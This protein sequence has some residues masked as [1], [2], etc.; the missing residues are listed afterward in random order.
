ML[1][2]DLETYIEVNKR[3][4]EVNIKVKENQD[5]IIAL[6]SACKVVVER[7]ATEQEK[8]T[9]ALTDISNAIFKL[10]VVYVAGLLAIVAQIIEIFMK[11]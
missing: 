9:K 6:L 2:K 1:D 5:A 4:T 10:E 11:K 3:T 7:L 8:Q